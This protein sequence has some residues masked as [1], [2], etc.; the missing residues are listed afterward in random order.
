MHIHI[1]LDEVAGVEVHILHLMGFPDIGNIG[2]LGIG[3]PGIRPVVYFQHFHRNALRAGGFA[4]GRSHIQPECVHTRR[5]GTG[6]IGEVIAIGPIARIAAL[7]GQICRCGFPFRILHRQLPACD[8]GR[9]RVRRHHNGERRIGKG[10]AVVA[11][12]KPYGREYGRIHLDRSL[13]GPGDTGRIPHGCAYRH[14]SEQGQVGRNRIDD[15]LLKRNA[16]EFHG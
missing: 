7:G 15:F 4:V 16:R 13:E 3:I 8:I 6:S 2:R 5:E 14:A 1:G 9:R 10:F 11:G 12:Q